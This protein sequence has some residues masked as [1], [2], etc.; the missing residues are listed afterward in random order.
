MDFSDRLE[1]WLDRLGNAVPDIIAALIILIIGYFVAKLLQG[2]TERLLRKTDLDNRVARG[3]G[4]AAVSTE[5]ALGKLV[6]Y[7]IMVLVLLAALDVLGINSVLRPLNDMVADFLAFIPN[8]V[9]AVLIGFIGYVIAK[10]V[11]GLVAMAAGFL[12]R[13]G[14]KAGLSSD[15]NLT[16]I[17][18]TLVFILIF[19]P[20][21]IA[22]LDA[23]RLDSITEPA[24]DM[25]R[26]FLEAIPRIFAAAIIIAL[27][28]IGGKFVTG[29]LQTLLESMGANQLADRLELHQMIGSN[30]LSALLANVAFF[31]IMFLG[32]ITAVEQ[33]EF[34][35]LSYILSEV[36]EVTGQ[37]AFGL[38][39]LVLG[40]YLANLAYRTMSSGRTDTFLAGLARIVILGLFLAIALRTMGI[41]DDIVN[42]A[43]GLTL[44]AV[45]VAVALSFGLGGREA[46][47]KEMQ[48][49]FEKFHQDKAI[50]R[51]GDPGKPD[52]GRTPK[53]PTETPPPPPPSRV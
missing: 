23:L 51:S 16:G 49:F 47:G 44:G 30:R 46:A 18:Q 43:F 50:D 38:V 25:L 13:L 52:P 27:F 21:L 14:R 28:Y 3:T 15:I 4:S 9:G 19:I 37:I 11:S 35:R 7:I 36:F 42:L 45:A 6:F 48:R 2:L 40:N 22:A 17:V 29:L 1:L 31:F 12:E 5:R 26:S 8:I 33:L 34:D 10:V 39:I 41:A 53:P 24:N 20:F 32:I